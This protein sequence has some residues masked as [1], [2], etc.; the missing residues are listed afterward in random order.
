MLAPELR[1]VISITLLD[2]FND[3]PVGVDPFLA[4][5]DIRGIRHLAAYG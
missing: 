3:V 4:R 1:R 5:A 2:K